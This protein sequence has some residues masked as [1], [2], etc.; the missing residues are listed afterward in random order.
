MT[1]TDLG[2]LPYIA[3]RDQWPRRTTD[4]HKWIVLHGIQGGEYGEAAENCARYF[5]NPERVASTQFVCDNNSTIRC[6]GW[7]TRGAS[8]VGAND[9]GWHIEQAGVA[10][11]SPQDWHDDYSTQMIHEQVAPLVAALCA[12]DDIPAVFVNAEGLK[13]GERG[14]TTHYECWR[15]FGGD[16][17]TD[18]GEHYPMAELLATVNAAL[19]PVAAP[20]AAPTHE[21]APVMEV[22]I[23]DINKVHYF[24]SA[25]LAPDGTLIEVARQVAKPDEMDPEAFLALPRRN[26]GIKGTEHRDA[27]LARIVRGN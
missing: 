25:Y 26:L 13:R 1:I 20:P 12:R 4:P 19:D 14:V 21:G 17:R 18:P 8:A 3:A 10:S 15:A 24:Y 27:R 23:D 16:V 6:M 9:E 5:Q 11:Q 22:W 7:E 2:S